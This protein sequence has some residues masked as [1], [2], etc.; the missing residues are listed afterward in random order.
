MYT[1]MKKTKSRSNPIR[2]KETKN[3]IVF[4]IICL[5]N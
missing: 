2:R 4:N 3:G 5:N 1:W